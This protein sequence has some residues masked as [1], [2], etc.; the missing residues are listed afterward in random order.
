MQYFLENY[1]DH[2]KLIVSNQK[3]ESNSL[4]RVK[5]Y[6][7]AHKFFVLIAYTQKQPYWHIQCIPEA[8]ILGRLCQGG[9]SA[10]SQVAIGSLKNS[11]TYPPREGIWPLGYNCFSRAVRMADYEICWWLKSSCLDPLMEFSWS[12]YMLLCVQ[13]CLSL[14]C[15]PMQ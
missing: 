3:E 2:P 11:G 14:H 12:A 13:A 9:D 5:V 4:Q 15:L 1:M 6:R 7:L 10:K 8:T